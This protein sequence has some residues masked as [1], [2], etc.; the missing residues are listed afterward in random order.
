MPSRQI[1]ALFVLCCL[2]FTASGCKKKSVQA[3]PPPDA[4]VP[5]TEPAGAPPSQPANPTPDPKTTPLENP[6]PPSLVVPAPSKPATPKPAPP[7]PAQPRAAPVQIS[8]R[9]GPEEQAQ[10][11]QKTNADITAAEKNLQ[12]AYGKQLN[13]AQHD[14]VEKVRGFLGQ[15]R[16]AMRAGDWVRAQNL[17]QK[18]QVLSVEL[19]NSL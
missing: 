8:P 12:L 18:A 15:A 6:A 7:A 11:E 1:C 2:A 4:T 17:A 9:L 14:L 10:A 5:A 16:E 19:V 3:A 13:A